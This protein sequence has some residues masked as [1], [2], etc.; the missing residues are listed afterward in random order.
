MKKILF[1]VPRMNIGGAETYVFT[2]IEELQKRNKY[3]IFLASG[4][5][6]LSDKLKKRASKLFFFP[7]GNALL[8]LPG[9]CPVS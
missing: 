4:G 3:E 8:Y 5:G 7:S 1:L 2:A 9:F 6:H